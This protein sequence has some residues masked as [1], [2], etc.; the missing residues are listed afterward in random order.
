MNI[1]VDELPSNYYKCMMMDGDAW[2][3]KCM[4]GVE[5]GIWQITGWYTEEHHKKMGYGKETMKYLL[6]YLF[7]KYGEPSG[8]EYV[9]NGTNRYVYNFIKDKF[10]AQCRCPIAVQ[11]YQAEDDWESHIYILNKS[12]VMDFFNVDGDFN[13]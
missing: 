8:I 6:E 3:S 2:L 5:E 7:I 9:W 1:K 13:T 10:D 12:K 4:I 11:K